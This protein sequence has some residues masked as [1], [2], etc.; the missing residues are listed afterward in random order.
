VSSESIKYYRINDMHVCGQIDPR[1]VILENLDQSDF[2]KE[3]WDEIPVF[4][5]LFE[6]DNSFHLSH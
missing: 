5:A 2:R 3:I 4:E 6:K 1:K